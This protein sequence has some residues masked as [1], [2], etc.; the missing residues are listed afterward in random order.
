MFWWFV[1]AV[2]VEHR[3]SIRF[4]SLRMK[5]S[6]DFLGIADWWCT[7]SGFLNSKELLPFLEMVTLKSSGIGLPFLRQFSGNRYR[8]H[9]SYNISLIGAY[10]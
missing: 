1:V 8:Q 2:C 7:N 4:S 5:L 10:R 6:F 9:I 3:S